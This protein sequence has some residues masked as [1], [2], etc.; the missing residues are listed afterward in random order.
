MGHRSERES[1]TPKGWI[2]DIKRYSIHDGPGI[3]TTVFLKGCALRCL[4][5]H[6]PESVE[7]GPELMHWPGRCVR[8]H[9][10]IAA[11]P[12][13][14]ISADATGAVAVDRAKCDLCGRCAEACLYDA[15]QI[16]GRRMSVEEVM[17]EVERDRIFYEQS[18]GGVTLSGGDPLVQSDFAEALLDACRA[19]GVPTAIDTAGLSRNGALERLAAKADLVLFDLKG[20]DDARHRET[21]GVSNA[22][23][24]DNLR[25]L[26]ASRTDVWARLPIIPGVN[27][28][29]DSARRTIDLLKSLG[30]IERVALLAYHP[31]GL[32][33]ARRLGKEGLFRRFEPP[34]EERIAALEAAYRRA[35]FDVRRGG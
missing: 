14:A 17:A 26:A 20:L 13:R 32:E 24:L 3:R 31:G 10:C 7:T 30:T 19:S 28:D 18:G 25:K 21:T 35:G 27:D 11:C 12:L 1:M 5:C 4:W 15:V 33:K 29:D 2:F 8:C 22:A 9:A 23:I 16:V 34:S 6:N